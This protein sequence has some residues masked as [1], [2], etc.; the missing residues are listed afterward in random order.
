M[1]NDKPEP[2]NRIK[3]AL[4]RLYEQQPPYFREYLRRFHEDPTSRVFA[5]LAEGYRRLGR[6]EEAIEICREGLT[7]HPDF[8]GG[9]LALAKCLID[10]KDF[11]QARVELERVVQSSPENLLAQRLLGD[12]YSALGKPSAALHCYKMALLLSPEDVSL[13]EKVHRIEKLN[14]GAFDPEPQPVKAAEE[15][16]ELDSST[17]TLGAPSDNDVQPFWMSPEN[18][19][20]PS[21]HESTTHPGV[22]LEKAL[23]E[24]LSDP[25]QEPVPMVPTEEG[26]TLDFLKEG[27]PEEDP[28]KI[29]HVSAIFAEESPKKEITTETLG[30]L[31]FA[32]GQ[33]DRAL[34]IFEKLKPNVDIVRKMDQCR[35][36]L[37]VDR[38]SATRQRKIQVLRGLLKKVQSS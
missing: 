18:Q 3:E 9:R 19:V 31:Y 29:E 27:S 35:M 28:F 30:D 10:K 33:F 11:A 24:T 13:A 25:L 8:H 23:S 26:Q 16:V 15:K 22:H 6:F 14:P 4:G 7:H 17:P 32:Q 34:R 5:P 37:G 36:N 38:E 2:Q 21:P 1:A 12:V 20:S